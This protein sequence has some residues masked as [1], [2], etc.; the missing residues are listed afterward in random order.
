MD[1]NDLF[2]L[3]MQT[4]KELLELTPKEF[5][6]EYQIKKEEVQLLQKIIVAKRAEFRPGFPL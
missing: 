4:T 6:T 3:L 5:T 2:D 1:I